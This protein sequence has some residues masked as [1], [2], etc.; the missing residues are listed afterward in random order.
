MLVMMIDDLGISGISLQESVGY[1]IDDRT[2][3][4]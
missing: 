2:R 3:L 4:L 1:V